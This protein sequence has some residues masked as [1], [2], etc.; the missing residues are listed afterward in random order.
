MTTAESSGLARDP[1]ARNGRPSVAIVGGG[2]GGI[3]AA[4][5]LRR[6]GYDD[7]TLF[8]RGERV[9]GVWNFN[10]YPGD[11]LRRPLP[12]LRVLV[13]AQS[14]LVAAL[15][16]GAEIQAYL[17]D[18]ARREGVLDRVRL[19]PRSRARLRRGAR[20]L[21]ARYERREHEA[22]VLVTAC[23]QLSVPKIPRSPASTTSRGRRSTPRAGTTTS[24]WRASAWR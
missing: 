3:S 2:F 21:D 20:P 24:T 18:V 4:V 6:A 5:L 9:G 7:L 13:R 22:D 1:Y 23:G 14:R 8:E 19:G 15:L 11:R 12:P 17:E 16:A 10:S